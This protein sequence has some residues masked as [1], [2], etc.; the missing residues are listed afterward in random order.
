MEM[1]RGQMGQKRVKTE[2]FWVKMKQL[3]G[4]KAKVS[5]IFLAGGV[6]KVFV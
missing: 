2:G 3:K 1:K 5:Y 4:L 6:L